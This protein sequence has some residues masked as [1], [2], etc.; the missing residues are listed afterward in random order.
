[1]RTSLPKR[2]LQTLITASCGFGMSACFGGL[3]SDGTNHQA[4]NNA[5]VACDGCGPRLS[6]PAST[7]AYTEPLSPTS[8]LVV[9]IF[10][11]EVDRESWVP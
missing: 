2:I 10:I 4:L 6:L 11:S 9:P 8:M 5:Q 3:V 1:M 7:A